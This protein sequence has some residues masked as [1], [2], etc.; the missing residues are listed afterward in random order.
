MSRMFPKDGISWQELKQSMH[1]SK[2]D[3]IKWR[4]GRMTVGTYYIDDA[5]Q[6]IT[7]E[8]YGSFIH[9]NALYAGRA[10]H[11]LSRFQDELLEMA[12]EILNGAEGAGGIITSG[13]TESIMQAIKA[14]R[15]WAR[16]HKPE[17]K[18]PRLVLPRTAHPAFNKAADYMD[19]MVE[20]IPQGEDFRADVEAISKAIDENTIGIVGSA[21]CWPFGVI[22]P[23]RE[24]AE[25]AERNGIWF[26]V[27]GCLGG[28][29]IPFVRKLGYE[30][31]DFDFTIP[32]VWSLSADL[33]KYGYAAKGASVVMF[34]EAELKAY[35]TFCFD[36]WPSGSY[37]TTTQ[38]GSR[39]GGALAAAWAVMKYLGEEGYL[40]AT[41][42]LMNARDKLL[43]SIEGIEGLHVHGKPHTGNVS[44]GSTTYDINAV[45]EGMI[46]R[47]WIVGRG[48][49]PDSILFQCTPIHV[50]SID[51]YIQDLAAT[52]K[53]VGEG[54]VGASVEEAVY[55]K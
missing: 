33:H 52:V 54:K 46:R 34:R 53:D 36:D 6:D 19:I 11:S 40:A 5:L 38:A 29:L 15:N 25:V 45:A 27:D 47:G 32:G 37:T 55:T 30:I 12:R 49:E 7:R 20:R 21:P 23:I 1:Q 41:R 22:D 51:Q 14:A 31:P 48:K 8:A 39:S 16:K 4:E 13:G 18:T 43:T 2:D 17:I 24:L 50:L 3:D 42:D 10:F 35:A 9:S 26:H 44:Y 28:F